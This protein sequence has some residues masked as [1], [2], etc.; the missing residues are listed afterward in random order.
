MVQLKDMAKQ[1]GVSLKLTKS[2]VIEM[3]D[4]LE[5]GVDHSGLAGKALTAAKQKHS[6]PPLKNKEQLAKAPEKA[7]GRQMAEQA[8]QQALESASSSRKA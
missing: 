4:G 6:I 7:A 3:L 5:P 1:H 2:E 8:K